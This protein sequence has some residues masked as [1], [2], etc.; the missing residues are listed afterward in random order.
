MDIHWPL[1]EPLT[2]HFSTSIFVISDPEKISPK[3]WHCLS[4]CIEKLSMLLEGNVE[5]PDGEK[6]QK[7]D[8]NLILAG[9]VLVSGRE[10]EQLLL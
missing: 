9:S 1:L 5:N 6:S 2:S 10:Q 7:L 8:S 3:M 4:I